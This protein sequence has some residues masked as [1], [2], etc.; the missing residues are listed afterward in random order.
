MLLEV[1]YRKIVSSMHF[2]AYV[3]LSY[4]HIVAV[5][6]KIKTRNYTL[7]KLYEPSSYNSRNNGKE[8]VG[9]RLR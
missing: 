6:K 5:E 9:S 1:C 8:S 7:L 4:I 3:L 2:R